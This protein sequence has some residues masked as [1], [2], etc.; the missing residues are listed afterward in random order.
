MTAT[1][2]ARTFVPPLVERA[3]ALAEGLGFTRSSR[4]EV[5]RLLRTLVASYLGP[6]A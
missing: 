2:H 5:G 6:E 3:H 4:P 1:Y